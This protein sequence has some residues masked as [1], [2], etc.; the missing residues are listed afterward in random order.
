MTVGELGEKLKHHRF[1]MSDDF[2]AGC[3]WRKR[4]VWLGKERKKRLNVQ[5]WTVM[6]LP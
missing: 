4:S 5:G 2:E 3:R 1:E 6:A